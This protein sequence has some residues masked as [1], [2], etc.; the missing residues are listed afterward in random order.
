MDGSKQIDRIRE[1]HDGLRDFEAIRERYLRE[2]KD[3]KDIRARLEQLR[4]ERKSIDLAKLK[5]EVR[6]VET[7]YRQ[8]FREI[9][10]R[11]I[12]RAICTTVDDVEA[13]F[14]STHDKG[15]LRGK[16]VEF[17]ARLVA[18]F[19]QQHGSWDDEG[20]EDAGVVGVCIS[21]ELEALLALG[22]AHGLSLYDEARG[23]LDRE[24]GPQSP[25][26]LGCFAS[27]SQLIVASSALCD[28]GSAALPSGKWEECSF[29]DAGAALPK[30]V[31]IVLGVARA[32]LEGMVVEDRCTADFIARNKAI[33]DGTGAAIG[34]I[35]DWIIASTAKAISRITSGLAAQDSGQENLV[36]SKT[37]AYLSRSYWQLKHC[38]K[39]LD[40]IRSDRRSKAKE[41][42]ARAVP[43]FFAAYGCTEL[44]TMFMKR[45]D[46]V[47]HL[48]IDKESAHSGGLRSSAEHLRADILG[49]ATRFEIDF[50]AP[51]LMLKARL[52]G[53]YCGFMEDVDVFVD[54]AAK[55]GFIGEF[56][57]ALY[58]RLIELVLR[59]RK[60]SPAET[61]FVR[62]LAEYAC[63]LSY[64]HRRAKIDN[65]DAVQSIALVLGSP[66]D[67]IKGLYD[68]GK[69]SL[70]K[71]R[72]RTLVRMYF[73]SN[74]ERDQLLDQIY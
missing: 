72:L 69:I 44:R 52:K 23:M 28:Y 12:K 59:P 48:S 62:E 43:G 32:R 56:F 6:S 10:L 36:E 22:V 3:A 13:L 7:E 73:D 61:A 2:K 66:L 29:R 4:A 45:A 38:L 8:A 5:E 9:D 68:R 70:D 19:A 57:A 55:P 51:I 26:E 30:T 63:E 54:A 14:G 64:E 1:L 74:T 50:D 39:L 46:I 67:S 15:V 17:M 49:T 37:G 18:P 33:L 31:G 40:G 35:D 60:H 25:S 47:Y 42:I 53:L 71:C 16:C 20:L 27:H 65:L 11:S 24:M 41:L 34:D 58:D 21:R